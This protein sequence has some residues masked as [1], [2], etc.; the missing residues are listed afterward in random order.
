MEPLSFDQF[1]NVIDGKLVDSETTRHGINPATLEALPPVPNSTPKDVDAAIAAAK[2]AAA[3]WADTPL[4]ERQQAVSKYA[5]A[6]AAN[7]EAFA[8]MLV[9]EQGK[10]LAVATA[11]I[12]ITVGLLKGVT[13]L[14]FPEQVVDDNPE[15]R[16]V[17]RYVPLGV[18]VGIVP[19]NSS[20]KLGPA[21]V[22]GNAMILKPS[23]FTPYCGLKLAELGRGIF[24]PGVLQALS[25]DDNLGPWLTSHPGVNKVSFTG[26][27]QTGMRVMQSCAS[28][29]KRVTLELGGNDPAIICA[30]VDVPTVAAR[31]TSL[32]L[33]NSG[34]V[35]I[36]IKRVYVHSDI[37][38]EFITEVARCVN[39]LKVGNGLDEAV[40][41]GPVQNALQFDR[42]KDLVLSLKKDG[43]KVLA[44]SVDNLSSEKGYFI[45]PIVIENPSDDSRIVKEEPFGPVFPVLKWTSEEDVIRRAN[46]SDMGLG[47]SVWTRDTEQADRLAK[48]LEAGNVWINAHLELQANA[49]FG[50]HKFSGI[51][52]ELGL[53][54]LKSYCN[55][56]TVYYKKDV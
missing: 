8:K 53:D 47:A 35:C 54:G 14:P 44:G 38:E 51:G 56:Q 11:E 5:D 40:S 18:A 1:R 3:G 46:D 43:A 17:T 55:A 49:T 50:G 9:L 45:N 6:L 33:Y 12:N 10:P 30:N 16:V 39:A 29:L 34:Q 2:K 52:S 23:P 21:L 25:G 48:K 27:T 7:A 22:A 28:T 42:V 4:A 19:W 36:A 26:S 24:P 15:R 31:V 41:I 37:Y 20:F 13:E 32:A